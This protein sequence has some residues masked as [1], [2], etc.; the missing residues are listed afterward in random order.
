MEK[1]KL[2]NYIDDNGK[3][4]IIEW[5][6]SLDGSLRK[7]VLLRLDRLK[8]GNFGD[9]KQLTELLY[10]LRFNIGSG[11]RVYYTIEDDIIVLLINGGDKKTQSKD[12]QRAVTILNK[13]KG[14]NNDKY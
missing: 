7:R 3:E 10:E 9:Y 6:K 8:D 5:L 4:P 1:F 2:K 14:D 11:Y 13:L 12:I